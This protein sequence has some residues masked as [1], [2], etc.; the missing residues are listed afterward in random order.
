[1]NNA[2]QFARFRQ[3]YSGVALT[4][5]SVAAN[6]FSQFSQWMNDAVQ[7]GI[8]EPNAMT[9]ATADDR[10][11]PSARIVLLKNFDTSGF[12]FFTNYSS[13]K[14]MELSKNPHA[15]L[16]FFWPELSR[17]IRICGSVVATTSE[18]SD[19]YFASRPIR[20]QIASSISPQS[21]M[22]ENI[23]L[24]A[25]QLDLQFN[26][27]QAQ[28]TRPDYWGGYKVIPDEFEFWQGRPD[29]LHHRVNYIH[30][31]GHWGVSQL[32]P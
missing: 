3:E 18:E 15:A 9:C 12:T 26:A 1:M 29:R 2:D 11:I 16:L 7:A 30:F 6:P 31:G 23:E 17:Q 4:V 22:I 13:R 19:T 20:A 24:L 5:K 8:S 21:R 10:G 32:A 25:E 27:N 28:R 14:G